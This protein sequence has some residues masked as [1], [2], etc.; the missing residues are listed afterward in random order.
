ML[1][2]AE[3]YRTALPDH[4]NENRQ[5]HQLQ[6]G[7]STQ[8]ALDISLGVQQRLMDMQKQAQEPDEVED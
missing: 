8:G 3:R 1:E 7:Q 4:M 5:V 6:D 2:I